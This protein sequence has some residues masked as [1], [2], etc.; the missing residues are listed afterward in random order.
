[1]PKVS[2]VIVS[3][4]RKANLERIIKAWLEQTP[5][6]WL[7]D[8]GVNLRTDLPIK[9]IKFNPDP[10]NKVRHAISLLTSGDYVIK[11]DDDFL[12]KPGL[13]NDFLK[14]YKTGIIG[15]HGRKFLG[16]SYYRNTRATESKKVDK[17]TEVDFVGICTF[18]SRAYLAF[19]FKGCL[20]PIEDLF[21]QMKAF[22]DI[23]K[24]IIPTKNYEKLKESND[25]DCLF[26]NSTARQIREKFYN[27]YYLE[28]YRSR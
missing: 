26:Y 23:K 3:Y 8:C 14:W 18:T 11:A 10:G 20:T 19:D 9:I 16:K 25:K 2:V 4:R 1:M 12:P 28:N 21:W 24:W 22:P 7:C 27:K 13:I 6:V 17:M 15:I 5:D